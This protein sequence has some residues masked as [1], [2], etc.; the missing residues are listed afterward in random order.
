MNVLDVGCSDG[1]TSP[2]HRADR[3]IVIGI[4]PDPERIALAREAPPE[5]DSC[6]ATFRID[7]AVTLDFPLGEFDAVLFTHSL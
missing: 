2:A 7:D 6:P 4:D 1:R 5:D 3:D